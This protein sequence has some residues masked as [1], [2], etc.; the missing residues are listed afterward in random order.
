M[1]G[2]AVLTQYGTWQA[3][4]TVGTVW[5]PQVAATWVPYREGRW[6]LCPTLGLDLGRQR[7][8]GVSRHSHYGRWAQFGGRW[9]WVPQPV[10]EQ[11]YGYGGDY[12]PIYAPAL[13]TFLGAAVGAFTAAAFASG[14][15]GWSPL[16]IHEPYYPPYRVSP[17][18]FWCLQPGLCSELQH[19]LQK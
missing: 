6:A 14:A 3:Q 13:V 11:G 9:G 19:V 5:F 18:L 16:G 17:A 12:R 15:I 1:T 7:A 10:A 4:P 2:A 8:L